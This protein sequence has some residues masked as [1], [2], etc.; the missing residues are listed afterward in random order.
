MGLSTKQIET[1]SVNAVR[2]SLSLTD[3]LDPFIADNDKEPSWDGH[4]YIYESKN[5]KNTYRSRPTSWGCGADIWWDY[6]GDWNGTCNHKIW[7]RWTILKLSER[8]MTCRSTSRE[9]KQWSYGQTFTGSYTRT[10]GGITFCLAL[11]ALKIFWNKFVYLN[12]RIFAM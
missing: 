3:F 1:F 4:V 12:L 11:S 6:A 10:V 5:H 2:D 9:K 8:Q 7:W